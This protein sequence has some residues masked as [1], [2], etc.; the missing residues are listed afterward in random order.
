MCN[1]PALKRKRASICL[2]HSR[3]SRATDTCDVFPD[4]A[5][6]SLAILATRETLY[7]LQEDHQWR[8]GPGGPAEGEPSSGA[9]TV[10]ES[11]P[12]SCV[13]SVQLRHADG[14]RMDIELYDEASARRARHARRHTAPSTEGF[15]AC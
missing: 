6:R 3:E 8:K 13:S 5:W 12:I 7:L 10:L 9:F 2:R 14:R 15:P 11:L 1:L 4:D